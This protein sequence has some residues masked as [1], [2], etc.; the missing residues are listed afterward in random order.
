M[1]LKSHCRHHGLCVIK[2]RDIVL[3][4]PCS[5]TFYWTRWYVD[6][7]K[8]HDCSTT[9]PLARISLRH[10]R[11]TYCIVRISNHLFNI[12]SPAIGNLVVKR[13]AFSIH[14]CAGMHFTRG[15]RCAS[16]SLSLST[17]KDP[18]AELY[19]YIFREK[20]RELNCGNFKHRKRLR[21]E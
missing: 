7:K 18:G 19:E 3:F 6:R 4:V 1:I 16:P 12:A 5:T 13:G 8:S 17:L 20:S 21:I 2:V 9:R 10:L 15:R 11:G 14:R